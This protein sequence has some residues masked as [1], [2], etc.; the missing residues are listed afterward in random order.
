M[1]VDTSPFGPEKCR[2]PP[3]DRM[4]VPLA[5][6]I[7]SL[8]LAAMLSAPH[9]IAHAHP[10]AI[11]GADALS[12]G[13]VVSL[14]VQGVPSFSTI[15]ALRNINCSDEH[16]PFFPVAAVRLRDG[17]SNGLPGQLACHRL[18]WAIEWRASVGRSCGLRQR[19]WL[20]RSRL[21]RQA[22]AV[23]EPP[24]P[25][26]GATTGRGAGAAHTPVAEPSKAPGGP[27]VPQ[28]RSA[29][30]RL[31]LR[32]SQLLFLLVLALGRGRGDHWSPPS[33]RCCS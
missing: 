1:N 9:R 11:V 24:P 29:G 25:G 19:G 18:E 16:E 14:A 5:A 26:F 4:T 13:S 15:K 33:G 10:C 21:R 30:C 8:A 31:H 12:G 7:A 20:R 3:S 17:P 32:G 23:S 2:N 27:P 28:I 22:A 6:A